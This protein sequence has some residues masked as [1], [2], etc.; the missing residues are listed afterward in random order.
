MKET[1]VRELIDATGGV[2]ISG[3]EDAVFSNIVIDSREANKNSLFVPVV[4][5]KNDAHKFLEAVYTDGCRA[6]ISSRKDIFLKPD[7]NIVLV[8]NTTKAL[9]DLGTYLRS[10]LSLPLVGASER[11]LQERWWHLHFQTLRYLRPRTI[12]T[13]SLA[14][15]SQSAE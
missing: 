15:L 7:F 3:S 13:H 2:L 4:G 11:P 10:K 1:S 8:E 6:A 12:S 5:E 9:Q 14:Y